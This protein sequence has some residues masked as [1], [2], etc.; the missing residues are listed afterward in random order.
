MLGAE[1]VEVRVREG[2]AMI[3]ARVKD[4]GLPDLAG[5]ASRR[6]GRPVVARRRPQPMTGAL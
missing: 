6:G 4:P 3:G 2:D 5:L 1:V